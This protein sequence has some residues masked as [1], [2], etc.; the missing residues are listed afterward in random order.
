MTQNPKLPT[1][2]N[3][4]NCETFEDR[5]HQILDDRL[6]L[7]SDAPLMEHAAYC[8]SCED[9]LIDFDSVDDSIKLL[10]DDIEQ[11]FSQFEEPQRQRLT[12]RPIALL[13]SLAAVLLV[14]IA[15]VKGFNTT[16]SIQPTTNYSVSKTVLNNYPAES[17]LPAAAP[18]MTPIA[19]TVWRVT[20]DTSP[21][22]R[23][24]NVA[25]NFP[26][27]PPAYFWQDFSRQF[28][29]VLSYSSEIPGIHTMRASITLTLELLR[30]SLS[31]SG[32]GPDPDLGFT[33]DFDWRAIA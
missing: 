23:N 3:Q 16:P 9:K 4:L 26:R 17:S 5:I 18:R 14:C 2:A 19:Q 1:S 8:K 21:F 15:A 30:Q 32:T 31:N 13:A 28:K 22:S 25:N 24:F 33:P 11:I 6:I 20:P 27:I 29:P 12:D 7:T 10:K